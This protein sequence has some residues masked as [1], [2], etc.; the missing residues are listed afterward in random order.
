[1][2]SRSIVE[3]VN[4]RIEGNNVAGSVSLVDL[5]ESD[6]GGQFEKEGKLQ[7]GTRFAV[8]GQHCGRSSV[9]LVP[10][11][12]SDSF[13]RCVCMA[14]RAHPVARRCPTPLRVRA[15]RTTGMTCCS[16]QSAWWVG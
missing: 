3:L 4:V 6:Q 10:T 13:V 14:Q 11:S 9:S 7:D 8:D 15:V 16:R 12:S 1:M 2:A 5:D